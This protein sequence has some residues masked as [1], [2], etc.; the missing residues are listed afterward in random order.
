MATAGAELAGLAATPAEAAGLPGT[1]AEA[2]AAA[3]GTG[4]A[5]AAPPQADN[6]TS[7]V[8]TTN[9]GMW[10]TTLVMS[11]SARTLDAYINTAGFGWAI[12]SC[13][14]HRTAAG[15]Y[16]CGY[17][18]M[19]TKI[20]VRELRDRASQILKRAAQGETFEI[21]N[22][23]RVVAR[24]VPAEPLDPKAAWAEWS[25]RADALAAEISAHWQ[26]PQDAVEAVR[27]QRR[28]L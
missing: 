19:A 6:T 8:E 1:A 7:T 13:A 4:V 23:R 11:A 22:R 20:G 5:G 14:G 26:G 10:A 12:C 2:G 9:T 15:S 28:D 17:K 27:E 25:K 16:T 3:L 18:D 21:C 24:L